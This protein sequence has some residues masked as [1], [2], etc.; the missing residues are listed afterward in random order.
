MD[1]EGEDIF[2][3]TFVMIQELHFIEKFFIGPVS[4]VI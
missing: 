2:G 3:D 1:P 4:I